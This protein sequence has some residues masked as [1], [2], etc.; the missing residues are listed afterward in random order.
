MSHLEPSYQLISRNDVFTLPLYSRVFHDNEIWR[1]SVRLS[2]RSE[3][4]QHKINFVKNFPQWGLNPQPPDHQSNALLTVLGRNLLKISEVSFLLFHAPLHLLGL[5]LFL[6]SIEH[7]FIRAPR[8]LFLTKFILFCV[9]LDLSDYLTE[10]RIVKN[11]T[12]VRQRPT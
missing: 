10:T 5:C 6:E 3:V 9:T 12:W 4:T 2:D 1:I 11:S 8:G 7:D